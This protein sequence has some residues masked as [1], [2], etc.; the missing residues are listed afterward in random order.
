MSGSINHQSAF[1]WCSSGLESNCES[2]VERCDYRANPS[3]FLAVQTPEFLH[4]EDSTC[5]VAAA[6]SS[7]LKLMLSAARWS[8]KACCC[9][10][11]GWVEPFPQFHTATRAQVG[12]TSDKASFCHFACCVT[13]SVFSGKPSSVRRG[14]ANPA[15]SLSAVPLKAIHTAEEP[16][17]PGPRWS[18]HGRRV[19]NDDE[20][21][22]H[23]LSF[24]RLFLPYFLL[25]VSMLHEHTSCHR[26]P[27]QRYSP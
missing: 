15:L 17:T 11:L 16:H 18:E 8:M 22:I 4:V 24:I 5:T 27:V 23:S 2:A 13:R 9:T 21:L 7:V 6:Q 12:R 20:I 1:W 25:G 19:I 26:R 3:A 10:H 14:T